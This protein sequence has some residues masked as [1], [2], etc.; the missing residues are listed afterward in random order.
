MN[1][2]RPPLPDHVKGHSL[3]TGLSLGNYADS[4]ILLPLGLAVYSASD[5][6]ITVAVTTLFSFL[7]P[8][9][10]SGS[11]ALLSPQLREH[12]LHPGPERRGSPSG[13]LKGR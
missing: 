6:F 13:C 8:V 7:M 12:L 11:L 2:C 3:G 10:A 9:L 1:R 5:S 4:L